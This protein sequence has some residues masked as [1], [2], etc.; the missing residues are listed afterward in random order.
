MF[1][2]GKRNEVSIK[3]LTNCPK[4]KTLLWCSNGTR[5]NLPTGEGAPSKMR[6]LGVF[7]YGVWGRVPQWV[8]ATP[9]IFFVT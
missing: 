9:K 7:F 1:V 2:N 4:P 8:W 5:L 6:G 3:E